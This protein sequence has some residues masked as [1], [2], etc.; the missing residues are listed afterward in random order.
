M[1][2]EETISTPRLWRLLCLF[3]IPI[4][5]GFFFL[6]Q[7]PTNPLPWLW[8]VDSAGMFISG[9]VGL[10]VITKRLMQRYGAR[11]HFPSMNSSRKG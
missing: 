6:L 4:G 3:L 8:W 10:V 7:P 11:G 2:I 5:F 1:S 9:S